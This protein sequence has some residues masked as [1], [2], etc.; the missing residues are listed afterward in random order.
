MGKKK[1]DIARPLS[2]INS[3]VLKNI[4][5]VQVILSHYAK[6][7]KKPLSIEPEEKDA[8]PQTFVNEEEVDISVNDLMHEKSKRAYYFLDTRKI[9]NKFWNIMIDTT[10]NGS[11][12]STTT[13]P[14]WWCRHSFQTKPIGCPL[15]YN[16]NKQ[17]GIEKERFDEKFISADLPID[18]NDFFETEG[19]FCS[20]PC[21]KAYI[22]NQRNSS[23]YKESATLL[24][25]LFYIFYNKVADFDPAPSWK[26]LKDYGGHLTI[27]EFRSTFGKLAYDE[28]VN[29]R[30][31]FMFCSSQY[32]A[33]RKIKLFRGVKE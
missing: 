24:T 18:T 32:I 4:N 28:T 27:Q 20:F 19:I 21:C 6:N 31:P 15:R 26:L 11:L 5:A 29:I 17:N 25:L 23:K 22:L 7:Q 30:R 14:C 16:V 12:P 8:L 10:M 3:I 13:K 2:V 9:Q 33:E 1:E